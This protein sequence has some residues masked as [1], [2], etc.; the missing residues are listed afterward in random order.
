M[1]NEKANTAKKS[2]WFMRVLVLVFFV[3]IGAGTLVL[4][5]FSISKHNAQPVPEVRVNIQRGQNIDELITKQ[6]VDSIVHSHFGLLQGTPMNQID[7]SA[8]QVAVN[9]HPAIQSCNVYLGVDGVLNI[10]I[11]QRAPM[12]RVMNSDGSG[13]YVDTLGQSFNLLD[14]AVAYVPIF[15]V[16]GVMGAMQYP[17]TPAYYDENTLGLTYLDELIVFG[18]HMRKNP[19]LK[20]WAEHVHL[21]SMGTLEVIPR[22]GR[23]VI[24]YGSIY[25]LEMKTKMLFQFYR[26]QVYI[27][28]LEKY[29]RIN[30]NFE[31]QVI[32]E[33]RGTEVFAAPTDSL[34][35]MANN[36]PIAIP[37]DLI[38]AAAQAV[39]QPQ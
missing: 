27:T 4:W 36:A 26:S 17:A 7:V 21:T 6:E 9:R 38:P 19:E 25:N 2:S 10:D 13:F 28:D 20:D 31:N 8:V 14:R 11:R 16:E 22:I 24:E 32:C 12:F 29:S 5:A 3:L 15:S 1:K 30:L 35:A 18:N 34:T 37:N 39:Q 23:H 33:K